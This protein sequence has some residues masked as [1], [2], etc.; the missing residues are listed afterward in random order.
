M[1]ISKWFLHSVFPFY[2]FNMFIWKLVSLNIWLDFNFL[3][4]SDYINENGFWEE[5][6]HL[7]STPYGPNALIFFLYLIIMKTLKAGYQLLPSSTKLAQVTKPTGSQ[8]N[9]SVHSPSTTWGCL[10]IVGWVFLPSVLYKKRMDLGKRKWKNQ[11]ES[12]TNS[13]L[14]G[15][16]LFL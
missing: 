9:G 7:L 1:R 11:D 4:K 16:T 8:L 2:H 15:G 10:R 13:A 12:C 3:V 5:G 14:L 6:L